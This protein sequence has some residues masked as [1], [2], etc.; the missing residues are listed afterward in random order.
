VDPIANIDIFDVQNGSWSFALLSQARTGLN[1]IDAGNLIILAG[2][3]REW[4][5]GDFPDKPSAQVDIYDKESNKW[6]TS[7]LPT[8]A[9]GGRAAVLG[10]QAFFVFENIFDRIFIFDLDS[11]K[12]TEKFLSEPRWLTIPVR[13]GN[14]VLFAGD[15]KYEKS[16]KVDI[17]DATSDRWTT[18]TLPVR[19]TLGSFAAGEDKVLFPSLDNSNWIVYDAISETFST[20]SFSDR[21]QAIPIVVNNQFFVGG[22]VISTYP[23]IDFSC[24]VWKISF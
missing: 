21:F 14:K 18:A 24:R 23:I 16:N 13:I 5:S 3:Y 11:Y 10:N 4:N 8:P 2:G 19:S 22:G 6:F 17:Y 7:T 20:V 1:G 12:W 9:Y 15:Y